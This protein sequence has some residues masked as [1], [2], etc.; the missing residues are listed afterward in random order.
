LFK[1][2]DTIPITDPT[3]AS[4]KLRVDEMA[5]DASDHILAA[6]NNANVPPFVT[7]VNTDTHQILGQ[8]VFDGSNGT[9]NATNTGIEQ[10][11]WVAEDRS[12]LCLRTEH[13][14]ER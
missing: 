9:P 7:L 3:D 8:I 4:V 2:V 13:R 12:V 5:Y 6:A 14:P 1:I 11:Q 10:P